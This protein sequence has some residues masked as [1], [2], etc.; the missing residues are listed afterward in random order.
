MKLTK[1]KLKQ[2]IKEELDTLMNEE[3]VDCAALEQQH[4]RIWNDM[5]DDPTS[6]AGWFLDDI[7]KQAAEC[8]WYQ[9][10]LDRGNK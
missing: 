5:R 8:P 3:E 10:W 6:Q 9:E 2:I 1:S 7:E 4:L